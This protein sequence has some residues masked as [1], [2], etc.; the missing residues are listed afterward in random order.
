M[1]QKPSNVVPL[2]TAAPKP[3][4]D[5]RGVQKWGK[6]V[7]ELGHTSVPSILLQS[8]RRL[9]LSGMEM[10]VLLQLADIWWEVGRKPYP[11]KET[12]SARLGVTERQVQ[13]VMVALEEKGYVKRVERHLSRGGKTSNEYD[14]SG[15]VAALT[16]LAPDF[17]KAKDEAKAKR[18]AL[19]KPVPRRGVAAP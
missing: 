4:S 17:K 15:L 14:L 10:S 12:L 9:R 5:S 7:W 19:S 6:A 18:L 13:R 3:S 11:S 16:K 1:V 2:K 8:Q